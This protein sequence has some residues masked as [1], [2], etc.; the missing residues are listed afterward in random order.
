MVKGVPSVPACH[1]FLAQISNIEIGLNSNLVQ[2]C[3]LYNLCATIE[4][5]GIKD[6]VAFIHTSLMS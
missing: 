5:A 3:V 1:V 2:W 6:K 4:L